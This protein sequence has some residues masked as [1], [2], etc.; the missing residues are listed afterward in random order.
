MEKTI[1]SGKLFFLI[2]ST[3][4]LFSLASCGGSDD[5]PTTL[6][7]ETTETQ[8]DSTSGEDEE[9]TD[10]STND[11]TDDTTDDTTEDSEDDSSGDSEDSGS[12]GEDEDTS[13]DDTSDG[14]ETTHESVDLGLS[15]KW[16]TMNVGAASP[17][18]YGN[19]YAWGETESKD[20]YS[21]TNSVTYE[22]EMDDVAGNA[23][24][25]AATA[26][27]GGT[28][29]MPKSTEIDELVEECEWTWT[30]Q[31]GVD[32]YLVTGTNGN[33]IFLPAGGYYYNSSLNSAGLRG[34]YWSSTPRSGSTTHAY[35]LNFDCDYYTMSSYSRNYGRSVRPV[36]E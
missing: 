16:A 22:V 33:S 7:E 8:D 28:W 34:L 9:S 11:S 20:T 1:V 13:T 32:G 14:E 36:T 12:E 15:V 18:D 21:M 6:V 26:N 35:D 17:E 31:D 3:F 2:V 24:Y 4:F 27:W 29:R 23:D 10:D 5:E 25:D 30:T 19:Y